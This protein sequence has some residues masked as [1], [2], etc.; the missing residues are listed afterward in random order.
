M[1]YTMVFFSVGMLL[2]VIVVASNPSPF[3]AALGLVLSAGFGLGVLMAEGAGFSSFILFL[4]YLGGML[5]VFAY[6][7]ALAAEPFPETWWDPPML[8]Y[9]AFYL[10]GVTWFGWLFWDAGAM[11]VL[12]PN[13]GLKEFVLSRVETEGVALMYAAGGGV[14]VLCAWAL[15]LVLIAVLELALGLSRGT[16]RKI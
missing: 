15:F 2:G 5:V 3:F 7:A 10:T 4:I 16:L 13:E 1:T 14:L 12:G 11:S 6:T 9:T 8:L